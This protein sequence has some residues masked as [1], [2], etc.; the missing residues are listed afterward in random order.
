MNNLIKYINKCVLFPQKSLKQLDKN[1]CLKNLP[2][3]IKVPVIFPLQQMVLKDF[4][5]Q[6]RLLSASP[7]S[8]S[9]SRQASSLLNHSFLLL[10]NVC[11]L[12]SAPTCF[13]GS[14]L[15]FEYQFLLRFPSGTT[16]AVL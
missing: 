2:R 11:T 3:E 9:V 12:A 5:Y 10:D 14:L 16:Q 4:T 7:F 6:G 1:Y 13:C 8:C 15:H